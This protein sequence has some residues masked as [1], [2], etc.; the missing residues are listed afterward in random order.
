MKTIYK[1]SEIFDSIDGEGIRTGLLVS[2]IRLAGCNLRC[3]YC[4]TLYA[5][6]GEKEPC[7]YTNM[8][9]EEIYARINPDYKRVTLTGGEPLIAEGAAEL[10]NLLADSGFEVNIETN[11]AVDIHGFFDKINK[12]ENVFFTVDY[13][14]PS[15]GM[16]HKMLP[17]NFRNLRGC[18]AVK[19]VCSDLHD[20]EVMKEKTEGIVKS[21]CS[22]QIFA[23]AV[24]GKIDNR[25][26]V[27]F[28]KLHKSLKNVRLQIQLHKV[29]WDPEQ[30]G[31]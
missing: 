22:A 8:T 31:V 12:K 11:G 6:F 4:D 29:I 7:R 1:V 21:G 3:S 16:E 10:V 30:K 27:E 24:Y 15:S 20:M 5:L 18:D 2:F 25:D 13:K 23:G 26:L 9:A 19:F 14:L 17:E 28:L